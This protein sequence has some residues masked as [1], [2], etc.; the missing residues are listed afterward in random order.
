MRQSD[1]TFW[2][3]DECGEMVDQY[4]HVFSGFESSMQ[5]N[6]MYIPETKYNNRKN[7]YLYT[8]LCI[9][10]GNIML[11]SNGTVQVKLMQTFYKCDD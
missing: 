1:D 4:K 8:W 5:H 7:T 3:I 11:L 10:E 9:D 6:G 2:P